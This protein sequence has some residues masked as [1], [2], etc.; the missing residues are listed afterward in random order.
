MWSSILTVCVNICLAPLFI[1]VFGW[2][3]R[4][5]AIA[6]AIAQFSGFC[7]VMSHFLNKNSFIHFQKGF[8]KLKKR[9][10]EDILS[11][12]MA[13][14]LMNLCASLVAVI[15]NT[16]LAKYGGEQGDMAIGA[17]GI[18]GSVAMLFI[19]IVIGLNMGMQPIAGYN[20]GARKR[21]RVIEVYKLTTIAATCITTFGFALAILFPN[22][23]VSAFTNN[24]EMKDL[25]S[26]ALKIVLFAF[27]I[28]GFQ[29]VTS[30]FFQS[31]GRAKLA[32]FLSLS[33]QLIF[34]IPGL[35]IF[36]H[37]FGLKGVWI[38]MPAGDFCASLVTLAVIMW[39]RKK[40]FIA[41]PFW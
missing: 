18:I 26:T 25:A 5:A 30:N 32:I 6:T 7:W 21:D 2:G 35:L 1:F 36:P 12:G 17:Y 40:L 28:V 38:A 19:M 14:F 41:K 13:P 10:V 22:T 15:V 16:S 11:I 24:E 20:Y 29:V 3:I 39:Q 37:F 34:L 33:R 8:F 31:I 9:I 4:G 23:I 27:P